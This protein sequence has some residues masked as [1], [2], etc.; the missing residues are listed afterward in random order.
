MAHNYGPL[1]TPLLDREHGAEAVEALL[2]WLRRRPFG[3]RFA[4]IPFLPARGAAAVLIEAAALRLGLRLV[5]IGASERALAAPRA[6]GP[7]TD[8]ALG[9]K[10][11]R[12]LARQRRRLEEHGTLELTVL[13]E[14]EA[15]ADGLEAFLR[16][17]AAG[18][19]GRA[20]TAT[21]QRAD[22]AA[23][24]RRAV[25]GMA[26]AGEA[27]LYRL[28]LNGR[29]LAT[30]IAF[31]AGPRAWF[32]KITYDEAFARSSPGVHL[33]V[34]VTDDL[35]A[36]PG[37]TSIDSVADPGHPM[38][39]HIFRERLAMA[40]LMIDLTPGGS[41]LMPVALLLERLRRAARRAARRLL[42]GRQ[43]RTAPT[44]KM[45]TAS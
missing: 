26:A 9:R 40:D 35:L 24:L 19:K 34:A 18:W 45:T 3:A 37:I 15:V 20:G 6:P 21:L 23:F 7:Y 22:R 10:K 25:A 1:G 41:A 36:L 31:T 42:R 32:W 38:I 4:L 13:T 43:R 30:G 8:E 33:A 39:D 28:D 12:E 2:A 17:E 44:A 14:P 11:R 27:R 16:L 5:A 29:P